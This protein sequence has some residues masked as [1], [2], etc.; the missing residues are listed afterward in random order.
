MAPSTATRTVLLKVGRSTGADGGG[1]A[2]ARTSIGTVK[3]L[4]RRAAVSADGAITRRAGCIQAALRRL[5]SE[6][7]IFD[8][9]CDPLRLTHALQTKTSGSPQ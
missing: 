9:R 7:E 3:Y 4:L 2:C 1:G 8:P 5:K 6:T